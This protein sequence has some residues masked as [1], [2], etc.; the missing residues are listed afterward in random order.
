MVLRTYRRIYLFRLT[1]SGTIGSPD[2]V[3][4]CDIAG[5]ESQGEGIAWLD[6]SRFVLTSEEGNL[7]PGTVTILRCPHP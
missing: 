5:V 4:V 3:G 1:P 6:E 7:G 2:P